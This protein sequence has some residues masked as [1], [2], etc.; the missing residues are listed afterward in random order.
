MSWVHNLKFQIMAFID[1]LRHLDFE[2]I[3]EMGETF[4]L[5]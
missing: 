1:R 3:K 2:A 5:V 4:Q